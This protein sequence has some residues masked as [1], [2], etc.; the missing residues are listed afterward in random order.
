MRRFLKCAF[1]NLIWIYLCILLCFSYGTMMDAI[2]DR[3]YLEEG[4]ALALDQKLP[5]VLAET[6]G[7]QMVMADAG[8]GTFALVQERKATGSC[9][10]LEA[11]F[12][13]ITCYLFG[14]FP[15]KEVEVSVV[16]EKSVYAG[17]QVVGIYG[18]T[19]GILVLGSSPVETPDGSFAEP[20]EHILRAGDY[21]TAVDGKEI[22]KKEELVQLVQECQGKRLILL[23]WRGSEQIYVSVTPVMAKSGTYMMG[24][25]IKDDM[26]GIGTLTYFDREQDFGALGHG[27][28]D[29]ETGELLRL[30][31]GR[32]YRAEVFGVQKGERGTPG[33]LKGIV[34][35]G[36]KNK[37]GQVSENSDLGIYGK[38]ADFYYEKICNEATL[39]PLGY[40]QEIKTGPAVILSDASGEP[41]LYHIVI[42]SIDYTPADSNKG[43]HFHVDDENLLA[44][45]GGI[46]QG[47]SGSPIIQGGK[48]VGAVTHVLVS[49]PARGYGIFIENMLEH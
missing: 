11:G 27:I 17:G 12:H 20:A 40:K 43:I 30:L 28:G 15:V 21:I 7:E 44:F 32:L 31:E 3:V 33:E 10:R 5:V 38:L 9:D 37:I 34:Y 47:L 4:Q 1:E 23:L 29:G 2:P 41:A 42:D 16:P 25:W 35:Y 48:L 14:L 45:T 39:Y 6:P 26:A 24:L 36:S 8:A 19:Q 49:D 18:A 46:V 22:T 13:R